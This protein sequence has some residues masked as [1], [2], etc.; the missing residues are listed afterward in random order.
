MSSLTDARPAPTGISRAQHAS[1]REGVHR[2]GVRPLAA[3]PVARLGSTSRPNAALLDSARSLAAVGTR[4]HVE[5][6][7]LPEPDRCQ[8]VPVHT[9]DGARALAAGI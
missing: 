2:A 8:R 6:G 9:S 5:T 1:V 4:W 7:R 3:G